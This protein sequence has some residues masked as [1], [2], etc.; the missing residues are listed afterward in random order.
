MARAGR[1][2]DE[3]ETILARRAAFVAAALGGVGLVSSPVRGQSPAAAP[4]PPDEPTSADGAS[5]PSP[6]GRL[7]DKTTAETPP[8]E[9]APPPATLAVGPAEG[10][11]APRLVPLPLPA[12]AGSERHGFSCPAPVEGD[13]PER[14]QAEVLVSA[15]RTYLDAGEQQKALALARRA[16]ELSREPNLML[17]IGRMEHELGHP[18]QARAAW[19]RYLA[20]GSGAV[21]E[22]SRPELLEQIR[23]LRLAAGRVLIELWIEG[24]TISV[25][26]EQVAVAPWPEPIYLT[27]GPHHVVVETPHGELLEA[28]LEVP[29]DGD[30]VLDR[31]LV[32]GPGPMPCLQP[33][34]SPPPPPSPS[35]DG[36]HLGISLAPQLLW[37]VA[38]DT[39][40]YGGGLGA[41]LVNVGI[42]RTLEFR[43][44]AFGGAMAGEEG[45][46]APFGGS[47]GMFLGLSELFGVGTGVATGYL[48]A[49]EP[50]TPTGS[51]PLGLFQPES[52]W[53]LAP[54]VSPLVLRFDE[55][56]LGARVDF[57][58]SRQQDAAGER[59]GLSYVSTAVWLTYLF[60]GDDYECCDEGDW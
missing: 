57:V 45:V 24:A 33:C 21:Y 40:V 7:P 30:V 8:D 38:D 54:H 52:S 15:A 19:E 12:T 9:A 47:L 13:S 60:L 44:D 23:Q 10:A 41:V 32:E 26:G 22:R 16:F 6:E 11:D 37:Q 48:L 29:S 20:C 50:T 51:T 39:R 55:L 31:Q 1:G 56:E 25:D 34:L 58:V 27:V 14:R 49:P 53:F 43:L 36:A 3:R 42:S 28:E 17:Y 18:A 59:F 2:S 4:S 46:V 5:P 35:R